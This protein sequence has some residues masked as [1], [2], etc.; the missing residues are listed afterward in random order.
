[1]LNLQAIQLMHRHDDGRSAPMTAADPHD[2]V[3]HDEERDWLRGGARVFRCTECNEEVVVGPPQAKRD[4]A[5]GA[6]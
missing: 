5:G 1:M 2:Q 3:R 6:A 4:A